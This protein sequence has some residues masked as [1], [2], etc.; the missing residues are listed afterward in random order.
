MLLALKALAMKSV[1]ATIKTATLEKRVKKVNAAQAVIPGPIAWQG[2]Y[3]L[4]DFV[5]KEPLAVLPNW[6]VNMGKI[7]QMVYV[8]I[9]R[10]PFA[11]PVPLKIGNRAQMGRQSA[12]F[13]PIL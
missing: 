9:L 4:M 13:T 3:V 8:R 7:A 12:S 2:S 5:L 10:F 6:T 11:N 1:V